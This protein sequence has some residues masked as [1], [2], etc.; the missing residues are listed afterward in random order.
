MDSL[1]QP[2]VGLI[3]LFAMKS[4]NTGDRMMDAACQVLITTTVGLLIH[5]LISTS[6]KGLWQENLNV[7]GSSVGLVKYDP[8][9]FCPS[10]APEKPA[11]GVCYLYDFKTRSNC[12]F[13]SWFHTNH[14]NK[15]FSQKLSEPIRFP[16]DNISDII[17][18]RTFIEYDL[19]IWRGQDGYFV[20]VKTCKADDRFHV[21][22]DSGIAMR[23]CVS[24]I[25]AHE[26]MLDKQKRESAT[27]N[28]LREIW[29]YTNE[30]LIN[31]GKLEANRVFDSLYFEGKSGIVNVLT[32]FREGRLFPK[33]LP[34]DNKL[35]II[36]H[37][38]PGTGKTGFVAATA[39]LLKRDILI[40]NMNRLKTRKDLDEVMD[41]DKSTHIWVFEEFDCAPGVAKRGSADEVIQK[42]VQIDQNAYTMMLLAQ[43]D[44]SDEI[45]R[46]M[47]DEKTANDD[48]LDLQYLLMKLDG[49]ESANNRIII[50]TT[51]HP[52]RIDPALLRPGRFG[53]QLNLTYCT[54]QMLRDIIGM[55]FQLTDFEK[56][57]LDLTNVKTN[58]WTP[59]EIL[60]LGIT[61]GSAD[62]VIN[63]LK[64]NEPQRD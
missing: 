37:G 29:E 42:P 46:Q 58:T 62:S 5:F 8:L 49:L 32:Q 38:P 64:H 25:C 7:I 19:P 48:R 28:T 39:N 36:L 24:S 13:M 54:T 47:R 50:A 6:T 56:E 33:H 60:Q 20:F 14:K 16:S 31:R 51:N 30:N 45:M 63:Y 9:K 53:I 11:N 55:V 41:Y 44:K 40:V 21:Y 15:K 10:V 27:E 34:I 23:E 2:L 3:N 61:K 57:Q 18:G 26:A 35:G 22:S 1:V 4:I 52:E 12:D 43:R 17:N 59:A